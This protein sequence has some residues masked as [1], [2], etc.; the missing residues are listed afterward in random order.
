MFNYEVKFTV[1]S[2]ESAVKAHCEGSETVLEM[3]PTAPSERGLPISSPLL[4]SE[5]VLQKARE[6]KESILACMEVGAEG[7]VLLVGA[8]SCLTAPIT[9]FVRLAKAIN[10]PNTIEVSL[11]VR[12]LFVLLVPEEMEVDGREMGRS[13]ATLMVNPIFHDICYQ[14]PLLGGFHGIRLSDPHPESECFQKFL[15]P[16]D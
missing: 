10:M 6:R 3:S 8:L 1:P 13:M 9:A 7:A 2:Q 14:V 12:F 16:D 5:E 11:P 15:H 4:A